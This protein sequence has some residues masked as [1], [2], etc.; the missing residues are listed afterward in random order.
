MMMLTCGIICAQLRAVREVSRLFC[1][2]AEGLSRGA[3]LGLSGTWV[4]L[5]LAH[6][7]FLCF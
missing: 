1:P 6:S 3:G 2:L 7:I 4:S 5:K